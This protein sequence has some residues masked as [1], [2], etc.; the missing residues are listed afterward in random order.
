LFLLGKLGGLDRIQAPTITAEDLCGSSPASDLRCR[1]VLAYF[2][3]SSSDP[4]RSAALERQL[5]EALPDLHRI[6][7]IEEIARERRESTELAYVVVV[8]SPENEDGVERLIALAEQ[9]RDRFFFILISEGISAGNYKRLLRTGCADWASAAGAAAEVVEMVTRRQRIPPAAWARAEQRKSPVTI[10]FVPSAGGVGNATL[11]TE[12]GIQLKSHKA[13]KHRN[14]CIVDLDFQTSHVCDHLDIEARLQIQEIQDDPDRLDTQL[15]DLFV[16]RHGS[17]L[18]V[19]AAP[20]RLNVCDIDVAALDALFE[21]IA[22]RYDW[23]LIDLPV[24]WFSWTQEVIANSSAVIVTSL[25]TIPCL[26]QASDALASVRAARQEA[27]GV[28][29]VINRYQRGALGGVVRR[30][31][32]NSVLKNEMVFFVCNDEKA[33]L[34]SGNAGIPLSL[35]GNRRSVK[36]IAE[37]V[38]FCASVVPLTAAPTQ[39]P[40]K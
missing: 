33:M 21:M 4:D 32:V 37:I 34:E 3:S 17:G 1:A 9:N 13:M 12:T 11:I 39:A 28:A 27:G 19:F 40:S 23:I 15:C 16:S 8:G 18:D 10:A 31:H 22:Q 7:S 35:T 30:Q 25:N 24:T 38:N 26:R 2:L 29:V 36:E 6:G 5:A 14:I 20:R